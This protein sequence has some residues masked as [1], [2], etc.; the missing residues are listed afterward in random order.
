MT[1]LPG[2][3]GATEKRSVQAHQTTPLSRG[4]GKLDGLDLGN[5]VFHRRSVTG[6]IIPNVELLHRGGVQE[7][8]NPPRSRRGG[9]C[10]IADRFYQ[11]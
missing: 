10:V 8:S 1:A 11:C 6:Q 9:S 2:G 5:T 4:A 7:A 3:S